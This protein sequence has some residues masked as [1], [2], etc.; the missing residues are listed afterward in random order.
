MLGLILIDHGSRRAASN[1]QL[2]DMATRVAQLRP[3]AVVGIAHMEIAEPDLKTAFA[4]VVQ[5]GAKHIIILPYF[6]SD[7]RHMTE[8]IPAL[9][10][11]AAAQ[12]PGV[13]FAIGNAL[14]PHDLLAQ[15]LLE[16]GGLN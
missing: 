11:D 4:D 14:G 9:A 2:D 1:A 15:L 8:D 10:K 12:H 5:R 7:G 13:T 16:R 3:D 6:L